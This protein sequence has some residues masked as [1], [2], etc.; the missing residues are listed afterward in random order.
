[1]TGHGGP[2]IITSLI[3]RQYW[4][5]SVNTL[6]RT[7]VISRCTLRVRFASINPQPVMADLPTYRVAE[8]Q[9]FSRVGIDFA[10]PLPMAEQRLRKSRQYKV[11]VAVFVCFAVKAVHLEYVSDL[12]TDAFV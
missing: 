12:S 10:G 7:A 11:Y 3:N 5:L 9:P 1:M 4:T 2:G 8:C 6:I